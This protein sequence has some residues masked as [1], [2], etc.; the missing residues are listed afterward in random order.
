MDGEGRYSLYE[1]NRFL[2]SAA[3]RSMTCADCVARYWILSCWRNANICRSLRSLRNDA[4]M[5]KRW[6]MQTA[7]QSS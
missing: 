4:P 7:R 1:T 2:L 6:N 5:R 3:L